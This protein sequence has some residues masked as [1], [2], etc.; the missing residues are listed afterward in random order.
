MSRRFRIGISIGDNDWYWEQVRKG[1]VSR[2]YELNIDL[3]PFDEHRLSDTFQHKLEL[4]GWLEQQFDSNL[5][6]FLCI[7][8]GRDRWNPIVERGLPVVS[9]TEIEPYHPLLI[10]PTGLEQIARDVGEYV[11]RELGGQGKVLI[12][13]GLMDDGEA[14]QSRYSGLQKAF[15][16]YPAIHFDA[17]IGLTD[18]LALAARDAAESLGLL[19]KECVVV[20]FGGSAQAVAAIAEKNM[21]ATVDLHAE[22]FGRQALDHAF[23]AAQHLEVSQQF[24]YHPH[25]ITAS[26]LSSIV[27]KEKETSTTINLLAGPLPVEQRAR[28]LNQFELYQVMNGLNGA[29]LYRRQLIRAI[30][31]LV[32][33]QYSYDHVQV[34]HWNADKQVLMLEQL[35]RE[36]RT[37]AAEDEICI[38]LSE[39]P[40]FIDSLRLTF[41]LIQT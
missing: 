38:P 41:K 19:S 5:H 17:I 21:Y 33:V 3:V 37:E 29:Q 22:Y 24:P 8:A 13:G 31:S 2:A 10:A 14:G 34:F 23:R 15:Q 28:R 27:R 9:L 32:R 20:G 26:S 1:I 25:L 12:V 16:E 11:A 4:P 39:A 18:V 6:A 7:Y 40:A 36:Q 35:Q 30:V